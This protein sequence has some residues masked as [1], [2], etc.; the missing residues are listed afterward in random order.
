LSADTNFIQRSLTLYYVAKDGNALSERA[1]KDQRDLELELR[2]NAHWK[3]FCQEKVSVEEERALCDPG[4]SFAAFAYPEQ[5]SSSK[6]QYRFGVEFNGK[7]GDQFPLRAV[8]ADM[9]YSSNHGRDKFRD[10]DRYFP[11]TFER[12]SVLNSDEPV[13]RPFALRTKFTF[14]ITFGSVSDSVSK[15]RADTEKVE[16]EYEEFIIE[17]VYPILLEAPSKYRHIDAYYAGHAIGS[18]EITSTLWSDIIWAVGSIIFV[19]VFM[20]AHMGSLILALGGFF[21]IFASVPMAYVATPVAKTTIASF[22]SLF[23][24][25]VIDIDVIFVFVDMW[26]QSSH[27]TTTEHRLV[28]MM[29]RAGK[30]TLATSLTTS[31]SFFANLASALQP[32]R[33]FGLFMGLSV[34]SVYVL[35]LLFIPPLVVLKER[36]AEEVIKR[37]VRARVV[38]ISL[39][40]EATLDVVP[41]GCCGKRDKNKPRLINKLLAKLVDLISGCSCLVV[42]LTVLCMPLF[43]W[44]IVTQITVDTGIPDIFP[45]G[46]N[47]AEVVRVSADFGNVE[48]LADYPSIHWNR[49][50]VGSICETHAM[51]L[52]M[53]TG[54][55]SEHEHCVLNWCQVKTAVET[56]PVDSGECWQGPTL[57]IREG[58][59]EPQEL[60]VGDVDSCRSVKV[61]ARVAIA[62]DSKP[63]DDS[64]REIFSRMVPNVAP[65][66]TRFRKLNFSSARL[67]RDFPQ[68][69]EN[70]QAGE[71]SMSALWQSEVRACDDQI[72]GVENCPNIDEQQFEYLRD[73]SCEVH[74]LCSFGTQ[75][76]EL[77]ANWNLTNGTVN[78]TYVA[79]TPAPPAPDSEE[80]LLAALDGPRPF[81]DAALRRLS[82]M[83]MGINE[84]IVA[85]NKRFDVTIVYGIRAARSTPLVG[86]WDEYWRFDPTFDASNP[87]AQR[88]M[89]SMCWNAVEH[90]DL[91]V[92][93][94]TRYENEAY[95][96]VFKFKNWLDEANEPFPSREFVSKFTRWYTSDVNAYDYVQRDV[97]IEEGKMKACKFSLH[98]DE[99]K[100]MPKAKA[101]EYKNKWDEFVHKQN[102]EAHLTANAAYNTAQVWVSAEAEDAIV[103]STM[104]TIIIEIGC[105]WLGLLVFTGDPVLAC[106]VVSL[107][108]VNISGLAFFMTAIMHWPIGP[109]EVICLVIFVGFSVTYSLHIAHNFSRIGDQDPKFLEAL[110]KGRRRQ[111]KRRAGRQDAVAEDLEENPPTAFERRVARARV[112]R[113][114]MGGAVLSSTVSTIGG[115]VFLLFCTLSIFL[116]LGAVIM[117]VTVLSVFYTMVSLPAVLILL[118]PSEDPWYKRIPRKLFRRLFGLGSQSS[119]GATEPLMPGEVVEVLH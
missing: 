68:A 103:S 104:E 111:A 83:P 42:I 70:W 35:A 72:S 94:P 81:R 12:P 100:N 31:L 36:Q 18:H 44:G 87:W 108:I 48:P 58:Q 37:Q 25:T 34:M 55:R 4:E 110:E 22:L 3:V 11:K 56:P 66:I 98:V 80:R 77:P 5:I 38:D 76:C 71:T 118:G 40:V 43:A 82:S 32:L 96:W 28:W 63:N 105:S 1:L 92:M 69:F 64:W 17:H 26:E 19:T 102:E 59:S 52:A 2:N 47:P 101:L 89:Y 51:G 20:W 57:K 8:F 24:V 115:S 109:I 97:W 16:K 45:S 6:P 107:V 46:T 53:P 15:R 61:L 13:Q 21:I 14:L 60:P 88:A 86:K 119:D 50:H 113:L 33:E 90:Q 62:G 39:G 54:N 95:C 79:P 112:A 93:D 67:N 41:R 117:A 78:M 85:D 49:R 75:V 65:G 74:V 23:L 30:S 106:L 84:P 9:E 29:L 10:L 91:Y 116:K 99:N 7:G 73:R 114:R 27:M